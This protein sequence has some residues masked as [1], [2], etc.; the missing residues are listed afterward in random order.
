MPEEKRHTAMKPGDKTG[1]LTIVEIIKVGRGFRVIAKCKCGKFVTDTLTEFKR[2]KRGTCRSPGCRD[3][4]QLGNCRRISHDGYVLVRI[5]RKETAEH[6]LI[7]EK[8]LG[9]SLTKAE[10]VH[11]LN[12]I[13]TDNRVENLWVLD[14]QTHSK[15]HVNVTRE[16]LK[17]RRENKRL[18]IQLAAKAK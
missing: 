1:I 8:H 7:M 13:K 3:R 6:R 18:R 4:S 17:I 11:H 14:S 12:G 2:K 15:H 16:L 5:G 9:R 10:V